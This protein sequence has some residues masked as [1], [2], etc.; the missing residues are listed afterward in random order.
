MKTT[1]RKNTLFAALTGIILF[2]GITT[3]MNAQNIKPTLLSYHPEVHTVNTHTQDQ[4]F[5]LIN[6]RVFHQ[7]MLTSLGSRFEQIKAGIREWN[8]SP[9]STARI[10]VVNEPVQSEV[11]NW[12]VDPLSWDVAADQT[13]EQDYVLESWMNEPFTVETTATGE[14]E[15]SMEDWMVNTASWNIASAR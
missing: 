1:A 2:A 13:I 12:M 15:E 6:Y 4:G 5:I 3:G 10:E 8:L 14:E 11:E 7:T 9:V